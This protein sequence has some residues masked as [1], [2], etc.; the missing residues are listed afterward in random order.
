MGLDHLNIQIVREKL[1]VN[2]KTQGFNEMKEFNW[3]FAF[4]IG[5]T[6]IIANTFWTI[7]NTYVPIFLQQG[8]PLWEGVVQNPRVTGLSLIHI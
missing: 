5:L 7:F 3:R 1:K 6:G 8:N 4:L 2:R